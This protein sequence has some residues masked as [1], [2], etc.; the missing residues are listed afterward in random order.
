MP[1]NWE[2]H[3]FNDISRIPLST[4][5]LI[6]GTCP[7]PKSKSSDFQWYYGSKANYMWKDIWRN[8]KQFPRDDPPQHK[9][10][11]KY[12]SDNRI[13]ALDICKCYSRSNPKSAMDRDLSCVKFECLTKMLEACPVLTL[14][15]ITGVTA[16]RYLRRALEEQ[17]LLKPYTFNDGMKGKPLPRERKLTLNGNETRNIRTITVASP[18]RRNGK[19]GYALSHFEAAFP[20]LFLNNCKL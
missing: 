9:D 1:S 16:E 4:E 14:I 17:C 11:Q 13:W 5:T 10:V 8:A 20:Q 19:A 6:M 2:I 15:V 18:S 3:P 7:P 12:L